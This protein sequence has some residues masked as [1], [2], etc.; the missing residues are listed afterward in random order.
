MI[1]GLKVDVT[2]EE[3]RTHLDERA[4]YHQQKAEWYCSR[5]LAA[6]KPGI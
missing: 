6:T 3:L 4:K 1:E 5:P 2:T